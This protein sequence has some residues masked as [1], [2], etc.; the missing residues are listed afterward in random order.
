MGKDQT[1]LPNIEDYYNLKNAKKGRFQANIT[2]SFGDYGSLF[3]SG[4]QQ[5]YWNTDKKDEW[6]QA[7]YS[8][9]W[10]TLNYSFAV[11][12]NKYSGSQLTDTLYTM[13]LSFPLEKVLAKA[14]F[15][16]NPI[17]NS[18]ASVSST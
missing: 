15:T 9:S 13:N 12:R 5:T 10:K 1:D 17:Q 2:H 8:N 16:D 18:Y 3:L 4:N 6:V 14:N 7:G 11:S